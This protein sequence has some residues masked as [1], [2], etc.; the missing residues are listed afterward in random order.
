MARQRSGERKGLSANKR[1]L[2]HPRRSLTPPLL[3]GATE[4][5]S[6]VSCAGAEFCIMGASI[7]ITSGSF[8]IISGLFNTR[9]MPSATAPSCGALEELSGVGAGVVSTAPAVADEPIAEEMLRSRSGLDSSLPRSAP[10]SA[11]GG[12]LDSIS[13]IKSS[14]P[15]SAG[16]A[17]CGD[18]PH[19]GG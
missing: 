3:E 7:R 14:P 13:L 5:G 16:C 1:S 10:A 2:R 18:T 12:E 9:E 4:V 6:D 15:L 19:K 11:T 8:A 17:C